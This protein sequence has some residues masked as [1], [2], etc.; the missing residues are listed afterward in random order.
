MKIYYSSLRAIQQQTLAL[1]HEQCRHC[2]QTHHLISHGYVYKKRSGTEPKQPVGKRVFCSD[3]HGHTG[4]GRTMQLYLD[5]TIRYLHYTGCDVVAFVLA[6][7]TGV[8]VQQAYEQATGTP[9]PRQ[10]YRWLHKLFAQ[11]S[12][13]RRVLHQPVFQPVQI[14][15][16]TPRRSVL[17]STFTALLQHFGRPLCAGYQQSLQRSFL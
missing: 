9:E 4:C 11:L 14:A 2:Q 12:A 17:A 8:T 1:F 10:A 7:L 16:R 5:S 6:L 3:R 15:S 13:Y